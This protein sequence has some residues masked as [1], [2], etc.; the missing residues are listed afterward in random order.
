MST[1][2]IIANPASGKDIRRLVMHASV[3]DNHEKVNI[4]RRMLLAIDA[5]GVEKVLFMP[6]VCG[7]VET[8]LKDLECSLEAS[9]L[10]MNMRADE[11]DSTEAARQFSDQGVNCMVT[12]GGDGTN[13]AVAKKCGS[14]PMISIST[15]T[16]NVFSTMLE[17][18][19]AG[20]AAGLI[21]RKM[22][23]MQM[24]TYGAKRLEV[25]VDGQMTDIA[26]VDVANCTDLFIG[27]RAVWDPERI[28]EIVL[29]RSE[30]DSIGLSS[31]GGSLQPIGPRDAQGM[32]IKLGKGNSTVMAAVG[33][34]LV[35]KVGIQG[36]KILSLDE[37]VVL[38]TGDF[39]IAVDGERQ[40]EVTGEQETRIRLT[41]KGPC[42]VDVKRCLHE[43]G[44]NGVLRTENYP[45]A[46]A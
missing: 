31:V 16:N 27:S 2:G 3:Y 42:V 25:Y 26:L 30:P 44:R 12:L 10:Q 33:P 6:D 29:T 28:R 40:I 8:A 37:E 41:K 15:G 35:T 43:A 22:V 19:V 11:R 5:L 21:S 38:D 39:T 46:E 4:L 1:I 7:L 34:G 45:F 13:R 20:L 23:D 9:R 18:T 17:G 36:Q 24:V 32:H 14:I